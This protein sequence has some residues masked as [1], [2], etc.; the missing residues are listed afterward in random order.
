MKKLLA[1]FLAMICLFGMVACNQ[2]PEGSQSEST[3]PVGPETIVDTIAPLIRTEYEY[4]VVLVNTEVDLP[5]VSFDETVTAKY[6]LD[7]TEVSPEGKYAPT[8]EGN[9]VYIRN[10]FQNIFLKSFVI[11]ISARLR[12]TFLG[13]LMWL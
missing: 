9:S 12:Q 5:K 7:G 8:T 4:K 3:P 2:N 11:D 13:A 1:S 6:E 10:M